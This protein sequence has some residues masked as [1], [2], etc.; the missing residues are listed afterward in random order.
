MFILITC[1]LFSSLSLVAAQTATGELEELL[2][3]S[4]NAFGLELSNDKKPIGQ[5]IVT[6]TIGDTLEIGLTATENSFIYL[7]SIRSTGSITQL[8][9]NALDPHN[10]L[11]AGQS[12]F[13]PHKGA[14][15]SFSIE[16][17]T[18]LNKLIAIASKVPLDTTSIVD[19]SSPKAFFLTTLDS[20]EVFLKNLESLLVNVAP[21]NWV[22]DTKT[23][24]VAQPSWLESDKTGTLFL[25]GNVGYASVFI[26]EELVGALEPITGHFRGEEIPIGEHELRVSADNHANYITTF[27]I[28]PD[29][30]TELEIFQQ[31][32]R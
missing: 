17:P 25:K 16:G 31:P 27:F 20:E 12:K 7:F 19:F 29:L 5:S 28:N 6:Y 21:F 4:D 8:L 14:G 15:Y 2:S 1:V 24:Y 10:A 9:P 13:F 23:L 11:S 22:G 3:R 18:G 30:T 26:N 32:D